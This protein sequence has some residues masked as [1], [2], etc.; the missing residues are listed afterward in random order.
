M[1]DVQS[2]GGVRLRLIG[3]RE[4]PVAAAASSLITAIEYAYARSDWKMLDQA[5]KALLQI[6]SVNR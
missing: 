1:A 4:N 6:R 2:G 3:R 5:G